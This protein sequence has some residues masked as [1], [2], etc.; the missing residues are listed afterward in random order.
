MMPLHTL[1]QTAALAAA[2]LI[3]GSLT[4]R[5]DSRQDAAL[6]DVVPLG[7][8]GRANA[9]A[10]ITTSG[11]FVAVAWGASAAAGKA[12]VYAAISADGGRTFP[13][14][15]QVNAVAGELRLGGEQP[16]RVAL[17]A[18]GQK[19][20]PDV[21]VLWPARGEP[22]AIKLAW[23]R[24]GGKTFERPITVQSGA[25]AGDRGWPAMALD[26]RGSPHVI[27]LD[28]RG[29]AAKA[30]AGSAHAHHKTA[31]ADDGFAMAQRS[32]LFHAS[33]RAASTAE[34]E[35]AKGVCY[36]C[37]TAMAAGAD[38][39]V[40]A[41]WRHV[42]E[43]GFRDIAFGVMPGAARSSST[44][45]RVSADDWAI[46]ACPDDGPAIAVDGAGT[47]HVVW[48]SVIGAPA[49]REGALFYSSSRDGRTFTPRLRI[50]TLGSPKPS[51]PQIAVDSAGRIA[52]AW[53][54]SIGGQR[55]AA[56]RQLQ[57]ARNQPPAFG[58]IVRLAA[59]GPS[60][61]P[62]LAPTA[63]GFAAVWTTALGTSSLG[64]R[65]ITLK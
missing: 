48:P 36:C 55:V 54:E 19:A 6:G 5:M 34:R 24:D 30:D 16:P 27:W 25:A 37:K 17:V 10:W 43:G 31:A 26:T 42:F 11:P 62:V 2:I 28:H 60:M 38:G 41:A 51:H 47:V 29:M 22:N 57:I 15:V 33:P 56:L 65:T 64:M 9:A 14:P 53:D 12:D 3:T 46:N 49:A 39:R 44:P 8:P 45:V 23:S 4:V 50:P 63:T 59:D 61:Y 1:R 20:A 18:R 58:E 35:V 40:F 32:A 21:A 13:Q 7:I 52:V